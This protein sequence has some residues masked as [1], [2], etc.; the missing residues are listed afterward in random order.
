MKE[1]KQESPFTEDNS[2]IGSIAKSVIANEIEKMK[3]KDVFK[4]TLNVA[5]RSKLY[6]QKHSLNLSSKA[7]AT[8]VSDLLFQRL[9]VLTNGCILDSTIVKDINRVHPPALFESTI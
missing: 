6:K 1:L 4:Y 5:R 9:V 7:E 8:F 2:S 3:G